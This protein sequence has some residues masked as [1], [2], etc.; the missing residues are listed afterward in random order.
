MKHTTQL[1]VALDVDNLKEAK[2]LVDLLYPAV[3]IFKVG[4]QLFTAC[5]AEAVKMINKKNAKVFLDLKY[6][7]IPNTVKNAV[8]SAVELGVF[9]LD[10]HTQGAEEMLKAAVRSATDK[11]QELNI[12]K[13]LII[14]ITVLTSVN[15]S[16][17]TEDNV[18]EA[19][20]LAKNSGLDG[21]VCS[22]YEAPR[23]RKELGQD[24]L[25]VTPGIRPQGHASD[26]QA[27]IAT[28]KDAVEAG[29]DFIVVGRPIVK[30]KDPL[31]VAKEISEA[32]T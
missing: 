19:A 26:D 7:D 15:N 8:S 31:S 4:S 12:K 30:A 10:V 1:I 20:I 18:L 25:I 32:I 17:I 3:K 9:M 14:G 5:G 24:F 13:P 27:R 23:V 6:H 22:V 21:V 16:Q 11:A 2:R 29:A 28:A